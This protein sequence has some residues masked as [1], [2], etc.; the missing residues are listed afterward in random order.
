MPA[1]TAVPSACRNS[2]PAPVAQTSGVTPKM[3]ANEVIR[4]GRSRSLAAST[5]ARRR[6]RLPPLARAPP[7]IAAA[8]LQLL[9]EF[10]DQDRVLGRK[11]DQHDEADLGEN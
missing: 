5:A 6:P 7:A 10:D 4:I 8:V 11:T 1:N 9:G 2:E 3:K